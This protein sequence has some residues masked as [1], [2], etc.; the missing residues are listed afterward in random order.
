MGQFLVDV[1]S[2]GTKL[3]VH[4]GAK[5]KHSIPAKKDT[6]GDS[7]SLVGSSK[8]CRD[9]PTVPHPLG[10]T[11]D[12]AFLGHV[13]NALL[14]CR[15]AIGIWLLCLDPQPTQKTNL[16]PGLGLPLDI[17]EKTSCAHPVPWSDSRL[18]PGSRDMGECLT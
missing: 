5:A 2:K 7:G 3:R 8:A 1:M 11:R 15:P 12:L 13:T 9:S 18:G 16:R 10:H 6:H 17:S 14:T 4:A